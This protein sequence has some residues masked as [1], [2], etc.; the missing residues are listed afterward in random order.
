MSKPLYWADTFIEKGGQKKK[1][2]TM[3]IL[4]SK[5]EIVPGFLFDGFLSLTGTDFYY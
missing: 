1:H 3:S 2:S 4:E 5:I